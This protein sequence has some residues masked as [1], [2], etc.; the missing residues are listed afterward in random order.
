MTAQTIS[1]S[2]PSGR[3]FWAGKPKTKNADGKVIVSIPSGRGF[4][5]G[6][7]TRKQHGVTGKV[8]IPS[9]RGF[10]AGIVSELT[11]TAEKESQSPLVGA[12]GPASLKLF[13]VNKPVT[14]QS[15]LVGAS[16]PAKK[17]GEMSKVFSRLVSI[18]SGRG[19]WAGSTGRGRSFGGPESQSPL[20]GA[21]GPANMEHVVKIGRRVS[22]SPLV[23]ASGPA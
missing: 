2:I 7:P 12:S 1:V 8:S 16:G 20:V 18:P 11:N 5:A 19:F 14:S 21:S 22:Q 9:G 3:G 10:W 6:P 15:P 23:G 4:W 13:I 17:T